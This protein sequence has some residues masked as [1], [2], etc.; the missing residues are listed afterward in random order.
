M[1]PMIK[2]HV[3]IFKKLA[4]FGYLGYPKYPRY[5]GYPTYSGGTLSIPCKDIKSLRKNVK[6]YVG[7]ESQKDWF[8]TCQK[9]RNP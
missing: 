1:R 4:Y 8:N 3:L 5:P 7:L 6:G 2:R 9:I